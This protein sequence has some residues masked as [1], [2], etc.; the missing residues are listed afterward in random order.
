MARKSNGKIWA[1]IPVSLIR[2]DR[3]LSLMETEHTFNVQGDIVAF[4]V[5]VAATLYC[6]E[7]Q[8]DGHISLGGIRS[9]FPS[10]FSNNGFLD[11]AIETA[12]SSGLIANDPDN[13]DGK[14]FIL[15]D[16]EI[17]NDTS[18]EI[19]HNLEKRRNAANRRWGNEKIQLG[20]EDNE[21]PA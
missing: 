4:A 16:Y 7:Q 15:P 14:H 21:G 10:T 6:R 5:Y 12:L 13:S 18:E 3:I 19:E 1:K 9:L 8:T 20:E 2:D 17:Y 11:A